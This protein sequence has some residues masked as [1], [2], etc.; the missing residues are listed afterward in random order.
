[1]KQKQNSP[2]PQ[3]ALRPVIVCTKF[4]GVFFGYAAETSGDRFNLKNSRM[5]IRFGTTKGFM[6][7]AETG[8]TANSRISARADI[9]VREVTAVAEVTEA[10][11]AAWEAA[12]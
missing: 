2:T 9:E 4:R 11:C 7:L 8:P 1:M 12:K 10:A 5:A 6:Q 3:T